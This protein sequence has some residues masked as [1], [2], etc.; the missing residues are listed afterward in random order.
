MIK[1]RLFAIIVLLL[2]GLNFGKIY[3]Q[4]PG[5]N[6]GK[7]LSVMKREFPELRYIKTDSKGDEYEDGYP[8]DG[9]AVFFYFRNNAVVEECMIMRDTNDFPYMW[10]NA[11]VK[12][13]EKS[14]FRN[15][16]HQEAGHYTYT[17]SNFKVDLIYVAENRQNTALIV[18]S[19]I[20]NNYSSQTTAKKRNVQQYS[21]PSQW[22]QVKVV[23]DESDVYG[24]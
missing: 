22:Y 3:A 9:I 12:A 24:L 8:Q 17:Y 1:E 19:P 7:S 4:E 2:L 23:Y 16:D 5:N 18:Y 13:F 6:L 10:F 11:Q 20:L 15:R 14:R 21:T